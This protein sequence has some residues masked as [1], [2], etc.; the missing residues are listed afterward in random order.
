MVTATMGADLL[1][2]PEVAVALGLSTET[3]RRMIRSGEIAAVRVSPRSLRVAR[4]EVERHVRERRVGA[5]A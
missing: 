2:V 5:G 1:S 4:G 3:V